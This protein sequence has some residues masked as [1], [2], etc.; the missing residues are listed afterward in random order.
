MCYFFIKTLISHVFN[1]A[2]LLLPNRQQ[3]YS[4]QPPIAFDGLQA[5]NNAKGIVKKVS[6]TMEICDF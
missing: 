3:L 5:A 4:I 1:M 6:E 2:S